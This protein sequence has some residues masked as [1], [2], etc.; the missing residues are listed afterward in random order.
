M[1]K[2][3]DTLIWEY[4]NNPWTRNLS[5]DKLAERNFDYK[6][7]NYD[8]ITSKGKV[9]F[10]DIDLSVAWDYSGEDV[11]ITNKI[12]D[13]HKEK[14]IVDNKVLKK[15]EIPLLR[16]LISMELAWVKISRDRLKWIWIQLENEIRS[17]KKEI[18]TLAWEDFNIQSSKQVWD[19][20]FEKLW[21][22]KL[23]K[24]KTWWSVSAEVLWDLAHD[25]PLAKLIVDYR[26]YSKLLS[27]YVE[28]LIE[29][30]DDNDF[31]HTSYNQTVTTTWRLSSTKPNLQNIPISE[32]LAWEIRDAFISRFEW[33]KI[34]SFDYSQVEVRLLAILSWDKNLLWAFKNNLDIHNKTAEFIFWKKTISS[35]E[36]K[37]SKAVNFWIIYG[38]SSFG[39]SKQLWIPIKDAKNYI[40]EFYENYPETKVFFD[41]TIKFCEK[42]GYVETIFWRRRYINA[43]NDRNSI[44]KKSAER[45]AINM[46][47]QWAS[48]DIIKIAMIWI[49]KFLKKSKLKSKMVMQVHDELVFD[50]FP[51]E[52]Y[53]LWKEITKIMQNVI[54]DEEI[55]IKKE[56]LIDLKV[57]LWIANTWR[58]AK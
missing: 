6:M 52:E 57:N 48:A 44:F 5:L 2:F 47:I 4:I 24:T 54:K 49:D 21:L 13:L 22:P 11:Y 25:Y 53:V 41:N 34:I 29:L 17:L 14:K 10:K 58:D 31:V 36:R 30:L 1:V 19:I 50:L 16:V 56:N 35:S 43:I 20:L 15:I 38:I 12:Y 33:W 45:E 26:H 40:Y 37:I 7:I 28:W 3:Y 55:K 8:K 46:P 27:T 39:L 18:H 23:K 9:N 42:N 32:S 51:W